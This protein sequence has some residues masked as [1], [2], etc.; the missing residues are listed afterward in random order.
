M[1]NEEVSIK[2][3]EV[4]G[5]SLRNEGRIKNLEQSQEALNALARSVEVMANEQ[6][7]QTAAIAGIKNDVSKLSTKVEGIEQ[8]PAKRWDGIWDKV[9]TVVITAII[10]FFLARMG[11]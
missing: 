6:K 4:D 7:H 5:R 3:T 2:L 1:T 11:L 8:K 10:T 9:L